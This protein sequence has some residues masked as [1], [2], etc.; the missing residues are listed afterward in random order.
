VKRF[1]RRSE[2]ASEQVGLSDGRCVGYDQYGA[3]DGRPIFYFHGVPSSRLDFC[4]F[5]D[6]EVVRRA[7]ARIIAIDRPGC[8]LSTFKPGRRIA[9]WPNDVTAVADHLG[10]D[11]FE[12]LGWSGGAP[13]A[14][15]CAALIPDRV[16]SA[17]VA[18]ALGPHDVP[19]LVEG[20]SPETLRFFTL[21]RDRP[22]IGRM[23][24]RLMAFGA[25]RNP[26]RFLERS[27][28]ALPPADRDVLRTPGV[29]S[30]Y[31][32]AVLEAFR[33]GPRGAQLDAALLASSWDFDPRAIGIPVH[34]WHG[35]R[36]TDAPPAMG[37][38]IAASVP[39]CRAV[40][41]PDEGHI[42]LVVN[43]VELIL[44]NP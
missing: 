1:E 7:G 41:V 40:F 17:V 19:G 5:N 4:M 32:D 13:Y 26:E 25:R 37:S 15:A 27:M 8:G 10:I 12:V 35:E 39:G 38:W 18:S 24:D 3:V 43:R 42:S 29:A 9:D 30:A 20:M 22:E 34:L 28:S 36:D 33:R 31:V 6:D 14:L 11:R 44:S 2:D 21:N 16:I 23:F